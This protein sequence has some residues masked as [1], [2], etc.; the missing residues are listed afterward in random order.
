M[1]KKLINGYKKS[2]ISSLDLN[3]Q[4]VIYH[5]KLPTTDTA[6]ALTL[7][8]F[9]RQVFLRSV[10][11]FAFIA[12]LG[13]ISY[14]QELLNGY[15]KTAA[16]NNPGLQYRFNEY[17]AALERVDRVSSLPDPQ[18]A[19]GY[20][21]LPVETKNGAQT[22]KI[23][24]NQ[25][26]PW[27]GT[28]GQRED[29]Y[30]QNAKAG[31]E[32]FEE[33]KSKLFFDVKTAYY[34]LFY[35]K[36]AIDITNENLEL[37]NSL[38]NMALIKLE[39][40]KTSAVD[41]LRVEMQLNEL[42]NKLA[43]LQDQQKLY[44]V[45]FNKL[46]NVQQNTVVNLPDSLEAPDYLL[47]Y[48]A[49]QDSVRTNN[50]KIKAFDFRMDSYKNQEML[51]RKEGTPNILVG[52]DYIG[53][54]DNGLGGDAGKDALFVKVGLSIP[55]YRKKYTAAINE[56][57]LMQQ[58]V[59]NSKLNEQNILDVLLEKSYADYLDARRRLLLYASQA[60]LAGK[61]IR[62]LQSEYATRGNNFEEI[63]R[64]E[65][66]LLRYELETQRALADKL[67]AMAFMDYLIGN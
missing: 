57:V 15:L 54:A 16:E 50:H 42:E 38:K 24:Y 37:L 32:R 2:S 23:S 1:H 9:I 58:S 59:E 48:Q 8:F 51:A 6:S 56:A 40:G 25:W 36:T 62:I 47:S 31:Y 63:L 22:F 66:D 67:A 35:I 33:E 20:F 49:I 21:I 3:R 10:L 4:L 55:M 29:V 45:K 27:F 41:E 53:I 12:L 13:N 61:A 5:S 43:F 26:F 39:A 7:T 11:I 44:I 60:D 46:L 28:L 52:A 19:F 30:T 17:M 65:K 14:G 64:M 18:V 34:E